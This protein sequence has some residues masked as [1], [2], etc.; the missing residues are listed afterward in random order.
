MAE[1]QRVQKDKLAALINKVMPARE[2]M[3][4]AAELAR[5]VTCLTHDTHGKEKIYDRPPD[6]GAL[7]FL[8]EYA[9]GKPVQKTEITPGEGSAFACLVIPAQKFPAK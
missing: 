9:T 1:R 2:R 4:K 7:R 8:E 3:E 5:G 6:I